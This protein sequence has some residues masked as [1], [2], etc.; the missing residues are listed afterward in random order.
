V[1]TEVQTRRIDEL[2][3]E[4]LMRGETLRRGRRRHRFLIGLGAVCLAPLLAILLM[5]AYIPSPAPRETV[6]DPLLHAAQLFSFREL[7]I[8]PNVQPPQRPVH[9]GKRLAP[10]PVMSPGQIDKYPAWM[11]LLRAGLQVFEQEVDMSKQVTIESLGGLQSQSVPITSAGA[12]TIEL[13]VSSL[14]GVLSDRAGTQWNFVVTEFP[15]A[16]GGDLDLTGPCT[17]GAETRIQKGVTESTG[18]CQAVELEFGRSVAPNAATIAQWTA[19]V[20]GLS[21]TASSRP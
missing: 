14:N 8:D 13:K 16:V 6:S 4:S 1:T 18:T 19:L 9:L 7:G 20:T 17:F 3:E 11:Q 10:F 15:P 21:M 2:F 12:P 5:R